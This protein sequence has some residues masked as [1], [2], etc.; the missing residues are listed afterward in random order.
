MDTIDA[1][2]SRVFL[3]LLEYTGLPPEFVLKRC[4]YAKVELAILWK[5]KKSVPHFY[6][7]N[8]LFI[9]DLTEYQMRLEHGKLVRQMV[10]QLKRLGLRKVLEF[11]GGIGEFSIICSENGIDITYHD[12]D[13]VIRDYAAWRFR[14]HG[15]SVKVSDKDPLEERWDAVNVMDVLEHLEDP[16]PIIRKLAK[17]ADYIFCNPDQVLYNE[18]Y[19]QHISRFDISRDFE[20]VEAYLWKRKNSRKLLQ[21][22]MSI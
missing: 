16:G 13:G 8:D 15:F 20:H 22:S 11:G 3:D 7:D 19:P 14:K 2:K 21:A 4:Q 18:L 10:S 6:K 17:N 1:S 5:K 12:L 9:Y